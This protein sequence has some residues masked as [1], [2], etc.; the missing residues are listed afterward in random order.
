MFKQYK[1]SFAPYSDEDLGF[2]RVRVVSAAVQ[3]QGREP[4]TFYTY[5]ELSSVRLNS[6]SST[7]PGSGMSVQY[8]RMNHTPFQWNIVIDSELSNRV[9]A[10]VRIFMMPLGQEGVTTCV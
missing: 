5:R 1:N 9:P 7:S 3:S 4:N 8:M 2:P 6:L 10:I